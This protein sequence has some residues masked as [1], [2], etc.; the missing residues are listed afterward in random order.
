MIE[1]IIQIAA[2]LVVAAV[3]GAGGFLLRKRYFPENR[4]LPEGHSHV[5]QE[6]YSHLNGRWHLYW[7]S[8]NPTTGQPIW[9]HGIEVLKIKENHVQ[10]TTEVVDLSH[11][12]GNM[13]YKLQGEIRAG[14]MLVTDTCIEDDS[15]YVT[16]FYPNLRN[17]A[18]LIGIWTGLDNLLRPTAAPAILSRK[19]MNANELNKALKSLQMS[20]VPIGEFDLSSD[21]DNISN[22]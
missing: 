16:I 12:F 20:L 10:G 7:V 4:V 3:S 2:G 8:Y 22:A 6:S 15:D 5:E 18:L 21:V 1:L 13:H 11:P 9:W 14:R 19:E 17:A